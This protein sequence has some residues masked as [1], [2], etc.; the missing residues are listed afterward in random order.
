MLQRY[1]KFY[2]SDGDKQLKQNKNGVRFVKKKGLNEVKPDF[3]RQAFSA[4]DF[5]P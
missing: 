1:E 2:L 5:K 3:G 4:T